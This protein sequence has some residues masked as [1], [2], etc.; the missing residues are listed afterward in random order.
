MEARTEWIEVSMRGPSGAL[1][2]LQL[3]VPS[4]SLHGPPFP[5]ATG[6]Y[7]CLKSQAEAP[8]NAP[9]Q[10]SILRIRA[11]FGGKVE[12]LSRTSYTRRRLGKDSR[13]PRLE[14]LLE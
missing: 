14:T 11:S 6:S 2:A 8:P 5:A 10:S 12:G 3:Q 9:R 1:P 7:L 4:G 13:K